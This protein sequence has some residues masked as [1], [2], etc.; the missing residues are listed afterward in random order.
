[1]LFDQAGDLVC[2]LQCSGL[3]QIHELSSLRNMALPYPT[4]C[5][6]H[7]VTFLVC[8]G[9]CKNKKTPW[10]GKG[11]RLK[12]SMF[13]LVEPSCIDGIIPTSGV[14]WSGHFC[15]SVCCFRV[16]CLLT[17]YCPKPEGPDTM[18][19]S[20]WVHFAAALLNFASSRADQCW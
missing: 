10:P 4:H 18:G 15:F 6:F 19:L 7:V 12:Y 14:L 16:R 2:T 11:P 13:W 17:T 8:H 20:C 9:V 3:M 5:C 1:M